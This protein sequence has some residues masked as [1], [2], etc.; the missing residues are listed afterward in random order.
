MGDA[1]SST[2]VH[3]PQ[4]S[5]MKDELDRKRYA[6]ENL[7]QCNLD[8]FIRQEY[9][10]HQRHVLEG[11]HKREKDGGLVAYLHLGR[12]P[13]SSGARVRC[14]SCIIFRAP[15][16]LWHIKSKYFIVLIQ[17]FDDDDDY[18]FSFVDH[19]LIVCSL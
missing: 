3:K 2:Y 1:C 15:H 6:L 12:R 18:C 5:W 14:F 17:T 9:Q 19:R 11:N 16:V 4:E 13:S 10:T 7:C 8:R